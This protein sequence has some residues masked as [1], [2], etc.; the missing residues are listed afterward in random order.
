MYAI[1]AAKASGLFEHIVVSTDDDEIAVIAR[2]YGAETPFMRPTDLANDSTATVPV[3]A[4]GI[5][6]CR[7]LG[8]TFDN[9][10]CIYPS[11]PFIQIDDLKGAL[12]VLKERRADYCF[13]VTEF[14]SVI[15]RA[16]RRL[17][18]GKMQ[19]LFPQFESTRTQ[20]LEPAYHDAGQFYWGTV[21]AWERNLQI[22]S[23]G[24]GYVI[25][26]WRVIDID[27]SADWLR[28]E[29]LH[30]CVS[31]LGIGYATIVA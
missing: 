7:A 24:L 1:S 6:V 16:L 17:G 26:N 29:I 30:K 9:V 25:P 21:D 2:Q 28:A 14:A 31:S 23:G 20:D 8:W 19:P 12:A 11:V 3:I 15:Q 18:D 27:T 4:H 22:H 13:P 5:A 10:C